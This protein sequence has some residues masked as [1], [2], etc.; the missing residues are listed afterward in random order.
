MN[1]RRIVL[2]I[3]LSTFGK[4]IL[5]C[6]NTKLG[7]VGSNLTFS[8]KFVGAILNRNFFKTIFVGSQKMFLCSWHIFMLGIRVV[9]S[10]GRS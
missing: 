3:A 5:T 9:R 8:F 1:M 4:I 6:K 10:I 2:E 7:D